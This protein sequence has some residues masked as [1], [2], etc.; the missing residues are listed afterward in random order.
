MLQVKTLLLQMARVVQLR[1]VSV[2]VSVQEGEVMVRVAH[3]RHRPLHHHHRRHHQG[4]TGS[5]LVEVRP[6]HRQ[7]KAVRL[8]RVP[9]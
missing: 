9:I 6:N 1:Q 3:R 7:A 8:P 4:I 5:G 2:K